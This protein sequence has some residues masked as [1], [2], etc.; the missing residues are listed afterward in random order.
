MA[1]VIALDLANLGGKITKIRPLNPSSLQDVRRHAY[2]SV[3]NDLL[4]ESSNKICLLQIRIIYLCGYLNH[5]NHILS[6]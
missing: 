6:C 1:C 3:K 5:F 2:N 4:D